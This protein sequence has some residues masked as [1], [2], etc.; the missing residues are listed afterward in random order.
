[1]H[2]STSD[3]PYQLGLKHEATLLTTMNITRDTALSFFSDNKGQ[4]P[5]PLKKHY[6]HL[7]QHTWSQLFAH[8][9]WM[10]KGGGLIRCSFIPI[11]LSQSV[12]SQRT[13]KQNKR[14]RRHR[15]VVGADYCAW[16]HLS[17]S[18]LRNTQSKSPGVNHVYIKGLPS[19]LQAEALTWYSLDFNVQQLEY[20]K[21]LYDAIQ[22]PGLFDSLSFTQGQRGSDNV[23]YYVMLTK[24]MAVFWIILKRIGSH[25]CTFL[26]ANQKSN[27][28]HHRCQI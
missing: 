20:I 12:M 10:N 23:L 24:C 8:K 25:Y 11:F 2:L 4:K 22:L 13:K 3:Y 6:I 27:S 15:L 14:K 9:L 1:M 21:W 7:M 28:D 19:V 5:Q 18:C 26:P 17:Q 16:Q